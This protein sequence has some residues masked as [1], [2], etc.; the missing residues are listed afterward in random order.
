MNLHPKA[1]FATANVSEELIDVVTLDHYLSLNAQIREKLS[2]T[3]SI[4]KIDTQGSELNVLQGGCKI[5]EETP[6]SAIRLE[7]ILDDVYQI[8]KKNVP[9]I[10]SLLYSLNYVLWDVSHLYKDYNRG[11]TLWMDLIFVQESLV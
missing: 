7:L 8:P 10:F 9:E 4:M 3:K 6:F 5:L 1:M 2:D 11:R